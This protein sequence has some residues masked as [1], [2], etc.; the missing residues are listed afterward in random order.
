MDSFTKSVLYFYTLIFLFSFLIGYLGYK[1][2]V[3][4]DLFNTNNSIIY[5][6]YNI[7]NGID[8]KLILKNGSEFDARIVKNDEVN[9]TINN[10]DKYIK[11]I[12]NNG[13]LVID[14][15]DIK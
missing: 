4:Y 2:V 5:S 1:N 7:G 8:V 9:N 3:K 12:S 14:R 10:D 13:E 6:D 11:I 15:E